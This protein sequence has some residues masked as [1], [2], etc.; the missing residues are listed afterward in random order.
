MSVAA[1][2]DSP[3]LDTMANSSP[4]T[5]ATTGRRRPMRRPGGDVAQE[6]VADRV[7]VGVVDLL[8]AV[9]VEE[10]QPGRGPLRADRVDPSSSRRWTN[11]GAVRQAGQGI[12][13]GGVAGLVLALPDAVEPAHGEDDAAP[14][15]SGRSAPSIR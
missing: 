7:A 15:W 4:P 9:E 1:S 3:A 11:G 8:E 2:M 5:R 12:V 10:D 13:V 14:R 6:P